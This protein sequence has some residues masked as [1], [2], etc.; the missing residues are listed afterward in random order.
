MGSQQTHAP[1]P[2]VPALRAL[3][4]PLAPYAYA[5]MRFC[6]GA[7]IVP[8]GYTKLFQGGVGSAAGMIAK[9][10]LEPAVGWAYFVGV[11]EF[12]GGILLA[13]GLLTRLAAAALVVE[14]AVIVFAVKSAAGFFAFK[15]G[16]ELELLLGLLCLA[17]LFKGGGE[18]SVDRAIGREL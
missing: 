13:I 12:V 6:V 15:G 7:T 8:H 18:L 3:Y 9:L 1:R 11:V 14:F 17:I 10:G 5:F 4:E 16:F 2:M